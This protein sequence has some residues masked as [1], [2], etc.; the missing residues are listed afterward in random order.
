MSASPRAKFC[1]D[2]R[3]RVWWKLRQE[4]RWHVER[5][6]PAYPVLAFPPFR[7]LL[8]T[9]LQHPPRVGIRCYKSVTRRCAA[10]PGYIP[11]DLVTQQQPHPRTTGLARDGSR[12]ARPL[13]TQRLTPTRARTA[14]DLTYGSSSGRFSALS[15]HTHTHIRSLAC[16]H[17]HR[18]RLS[19]VCPAR[20]LANTVS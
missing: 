19:H 1:S 3:Q 11:R 16:S 2:A 20:S 14:P 4:A 13:H 12:L 10:H 8:A 15:S 17:T 5:V 18:F 7:R 9:S 6:P